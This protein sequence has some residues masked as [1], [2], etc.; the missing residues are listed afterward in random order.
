MSSDWSASRAWRNPVRPL[1]AGLRIRV[2]ASA[3]FLVGGIVFVL[4]YLAFFAQRFAWYQNL[5]V[6]LSATLV[7]PVAIV[8]IWVM[9]GLSLGRRWATYDDAFD[10]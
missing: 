10:E 3:A 6:V 2:A 4:L 7:V 9:W 1:L 5:A 8:V